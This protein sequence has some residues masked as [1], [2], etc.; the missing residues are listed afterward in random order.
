MNR[1]KKRNGGASASA[2][3]VGGEKAWM[4]PK[5][6]SERAGKGEIEMERR[7]RRIGPS[8]WARRKTPVYWH[9][10]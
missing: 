6:I 8:E 4:I 2:R 1:R 10:R 5:I 7:G 3:K 9:Q